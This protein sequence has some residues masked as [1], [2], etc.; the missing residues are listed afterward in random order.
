MNCYID[1]GCT[2]FTLSLFYYNL[3][4]IFAL[5]I[6]SSINYNN[7]VLTE[8]VA[9]SREHGDFTKKSSQT[10]RQAVKKLTL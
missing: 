8:V 1:L 7:T 5:W 4:L 6:I 2:D 9:E 3:G 10:I